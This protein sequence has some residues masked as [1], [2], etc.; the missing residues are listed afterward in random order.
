MMG[1]D[2]RAFIQVGYQSLLPGMVS[3]AGGNFELPWRDVYESTPPVKVRV[4]TF[5]VSR[6]PVTFQQWEDFKT[7]LGEFTYAMVTGRER[8]YQQ[9]DTASAAVSGFGLERRLRPPAPKLR[10]VAL[11]T[12][13]K[14]LEEAPLRG[15]IR[16]DLGSGIRMQ[17][18]ITRGRGSEDSEMPVTWVDVGAA[19]LFALCHGA[20]LPTKAQWV[21][22]A[23]CGGQIRYAT[24]DSPPPNEWGL[25]G[26]KRDFFEWTVENFF[27][28]FPPDPPSP[29]QIGSTWSP[30]GGVPR[31][32]FWLPGGVDRKRESNGWDFFRLSPVDLMASN[33]GF[34]LVMA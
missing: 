26:M 27:V 5:R 24:V 12:S 17:K 10:L 14:S 9:Y 20:M 22:G 32:D 33:I 2:L 23:T 34:R 19:L 16:G 3:I 7:R 8:G 18:A 13:Q 30:V 6:S 25:D 1:A 28:D 4:P 31:H 11:G 15:E 29:N 21:W